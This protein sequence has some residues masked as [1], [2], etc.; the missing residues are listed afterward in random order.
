VEWLI[1][2]IFRG[3][4]GLWSLIVRGINVAFGWLSDGFLHFIAGGAVSGVTKVLDSARGQASTM[5]VRGSTS[6]AIGYGT[7]PRATGATG[8]SSAKSSAA[9]SSFMGQFI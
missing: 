3:M 7:T 5:G 9:A 8:A 4:R 6:A 1:N 2:L